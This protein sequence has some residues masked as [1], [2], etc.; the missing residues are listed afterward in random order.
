MKKTFKLI[1]TIALLAGLFYYTGGDIDS[2]TGFIVDEPNTVVQET[3]STPRIIEESIII[4][5]WNIQVFGQSK[6]SKPHVQEKILDTVDDYDIIVIQEIRDS[7]GE[8]FEELCAILEDYSCEASER[9]GRSVS[10]EQYGIVYRNEFTVTDTL[11]F[12]LD[13]S[14]YNDFERPPYKVD[15]AVQDY[16]FSLVTIHIKPDDVDNELEALEKITQNYKEENLMLLG[17]FNADGSYYNDEENIFFLDY[18]WVVN[19]D[20]DTTVAKSDNA[21]DRIL[22]SENMANEYIEYGIYKDINK[23]VSDHYPVWVQMSLVE[24]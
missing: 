22:L 13:E 21:Y 8:V 3:R 17:D 15:F 10:K 23:S 2:L 1:L 6:W 11:D 9:A 12:S 19:N 24:N 20:D 4:A 14:Q 5:N 16:E 18:T 7:S